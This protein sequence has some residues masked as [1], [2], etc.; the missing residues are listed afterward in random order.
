MWIAVALLLIKV[1]GPGLGISIPPT[2][3]VASFFYLVLFFVLAFFMYASAYAAVGA[4]S[5]DE[6]NFT[7]LSWPVLFFLIVP[8]VLISM[9]ILSPD[10]PVMVG[11]SLFPLTAP[12]VMFA[13][14]IVGEAP[15]W[16]VLLSVLLMIACIAVTVAVSAKVFRVGILLTGSKRSIGGVLRMLRY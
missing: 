13:R 16:Q 10:I 1:V 3:T 9:V 7:Q 14:L 5:A 4:A 15:A 6:Q 2:V 12:I 8:M 11:L